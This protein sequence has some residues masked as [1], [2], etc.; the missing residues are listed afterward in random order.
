MAG[1][2]LG[3]TRHWAMAAVAI[4]VT[5]QAPACDIPV[6]R[7]ALQR[8]APDPY[9]VIVFHRGP[10]S[11]SDQAVLDT[12]KENESASGVRANLSVHEVD[13]ESTMHDQAH[14]VWDAQSSAELPW[15]VLRHP[16]PVPAHVKIW[17]GRLTQAAAAAAVDSPKRREIAGYLLE[18]DAVVWV[19]LETG[20][21]TQDNVAAK[22]LQDTLHAIREN[23]PNQDQTPGGVV[24]GSSLPPPRFPLVRVS[25]KDPA[26]QIFV[27]V[28]LGVE[29]DLKDYAEPM[30]FPIFGRGRVLYALVGQ[31]INETTI[32][33]ACVFLMNGCSCDVKDENPGMDLLLTVD[34]ETRAPDLD[35]HETAS[36]PALPG[37]L[38]RESAV[39][40]SVSGITE[41]SEAS[42]VVEGPV[43]TDEHAV[44]SP[45]AVFRNLFLVVASGVVI[46][47]AV[48]LILWKQ[49]SS[50]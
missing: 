41:D 12:L 17:A 10:L 18:G 4:L 39:D 19:V 27:E 7:Y 16:M 26:E 35:I 50:S 14:A 22:V 9:Q 6:Y 1:P 24:P 11:S 33:K 8:W 38:Q 15:M 3:A 37:I 23:P 34:W 28:L 49:G 47:L 5:N 40:E 29:P 25:R 32:R 20:D 2:R 43:L 31:G 30:A 13:L 42:S 44:T 48:S 45:N 36:I 21:E 46:V